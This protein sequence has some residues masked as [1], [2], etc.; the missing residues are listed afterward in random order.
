MKVYI[1]QINPTIGALSSNAELIHRAYR[2]GVAA[3]ADVPDLLPGRIGQIAID[4]GRFRR[5]H[6]LKR[7]CNA[8]LRLGLRGR[9]GRRHYTTEKKR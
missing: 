5:A 2:E 8:S 4:D 1:G 3:G 7:S 9:R 6:G